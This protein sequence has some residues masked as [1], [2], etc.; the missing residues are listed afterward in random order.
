MAN[1]HCEGEPKPDNSAY[2]VTASWLTVLLF[3]ML[4][5]VDVGADMLFD[6]FRGCTQIEEHFDKQTVV[7]RKYVEDVRGLNRL[8][9]ARA[10]ALHGSFEKLSCVGSYPDSFTDMLARVIQTFIDS[11]AHQ[12]GIESKA[13]DGRVKE[14][15]FLFCQATD[16]V[17]DGD[18]I[19]I[20]PPRF[21][22]SVLQYTLSA[23][24]KLIFVCFQISHFVL[25][26]LPWL[27]EHFNSGCPKLLQA[28]PL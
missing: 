22:E 12:D 9:S 15:R 14:I 21:A 13:A 4:A 8:P 27:P 24:A 28:A 25:A 1:D 16:D 18:V 3:V 7:V 26:C 19:L 2:S 6:C 20:A 11:S 10:S 17:F 5:F 23:L